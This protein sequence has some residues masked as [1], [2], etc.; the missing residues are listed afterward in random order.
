MSTP[1]SLLQSLTDVRKRIAKA[2][3]KGL[4]E[5]NTK[6]SLIQPV[7]RALG[8]DTENVE[9]V[10]LEY[11]GKPSQKPV[12]YALLDLCEPRLFI[13]AKP[14]G[15]NLDDSR[16]TNQIMGYAAVAGV[17]W[18]VLTDGNE[19]RIYNS[20]ASVPVEEKLFRSVRIT[21][22]RPGVEETLALLS[23]D[24][25]KTNTIATL[26]HAH[27]VDRQ[28]KAALNGLLSRD[29]DVLLVS[30]MLKVTKHLSAQDIRNSLRRCKLTVEFSL[31]MDSGPLAGPSH[32]LLQGLVDSRFLRAP[33]LL[34]RTFKGRE[35]TATLRKDATVECLGKTYQSLSQAACAA[36]ASVIGV[37][38]DG[39]MRATNGWRFWKYK[40]MDGTIREIDHARQAYLRAEGVV[41]EDASR[42]ARRRAKAA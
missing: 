7:L 5:Q 12:D 11:R 40:A 6:T 37:R 38:P 16:W 17:E 15:E 14:L 2:G 8:W 33:A 9:E 13:E 23:K 36:R 41:S 18:I 21:D 35:L 22:E 3:S 24:Q 30:Q 4:N 42:S 31:P 1:S 27:F 20:H 28:V 32:G 29:N 34:S 25:L 10:F 26:W 19:Y 39:K